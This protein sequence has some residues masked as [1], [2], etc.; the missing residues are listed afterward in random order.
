MRLAGARVWIV[1]ASSGI[2][3]ALAGRLVGA[4][5]RV[6]ISARRGH[7][8]ER[9]AAAQAPSRPP[10]LTVV[11]DVTDPSAIRR[12]ASRV[13]ADFGG[14][15]LAILNAGTY[16]MVAGQVLRAS[17]FVDTFQVNLFGALY[18][19][20]AVLPGMLRRGYGRIAATSSLTGLLPLPNAAAYGASKAALTY[21]FEAL[22]FDLEPRGVGVT[23]IQPG[24]VRTPMVRPNRF[25]MPGLL[26]VDVAAGIIV[27]GLARE[28]D[29]IVF[30]RRLAWPV[31]AIH[32][33][34]LPIYRRLLRVVIRLGVL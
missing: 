6:A 16:R 24:F 21:V 19:A 20:E 34:P 3:E 4:G 31:Q 25:W 28:R 29:E 12:A 13:E 7:E 10:I 30:P 32:R 5:A 15:D 2:G 11:A 23:L 33:L 22:R 1:G 17:D 14:V 9:I 8:L 27:R 18:A 26:P